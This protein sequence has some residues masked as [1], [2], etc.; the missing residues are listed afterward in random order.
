VMYAQQQAGTVEKC[1]FCV[2]RLAPGL[3]PACVLTCPAKARFFGD[4]D[5]P[6]SDVSKMI[7]ANNAQQ[8]KPEAGTDPNVYYIGL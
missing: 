2:D 7:V 4:L 3:L 1:N 5:D 6:N 8:L